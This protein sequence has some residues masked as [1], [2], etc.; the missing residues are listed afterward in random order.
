VAK[1]FK[2]IKNIMRP[3][4]IPFNSAAE[5]LIEQLRFASLPGG[6]LRKLQ[7]YTVQ[8]YPYQ[9]EALDKAA[10]IDYID[11]SYPVLIDPELYTFEQGLKIPKEPKDPA[12][13]IC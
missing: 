5:Q 8:I 7:H 1:R 2:L 9:L 11:G 10:A 4:L 13:F 12:G 6:I 3:V